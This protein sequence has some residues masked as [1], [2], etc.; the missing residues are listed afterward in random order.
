M[1][2]TST[3][4]SKLLSYYFP[5]QTNSWYPRISQ[6]NQLSIDLFKGLGKRSNRCQGWSRWSE[7]WGLSSAPGLQADTIWVDLAR[8]LN[9]TFEH[10]SW[11]SLSMLGH[12]L[13]DM[14]SWGGKSHKSLECKKGNPQRLGEAV[15]SGNCVTHFYCSKQVESIST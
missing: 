2:E 5:I 10:L 14:R 6:I 8:N 9:V 12:M 15:F 3:D 13:G 7:P 1:L 11:D 4:T